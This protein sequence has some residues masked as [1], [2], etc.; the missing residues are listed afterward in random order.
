M[1]KYRRRA[2]R[3]PPSLRPMIESSMQEVVG[4]V[5][6]ITRD[7]LMRMVKDAI[8]EY[9]GLPGSRKARDALER[10]VPE[11]LD[12]MVRD[13]RLMEHCGRLY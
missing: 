11:V 9:A 1:G 12:G 2:A 5:Q 8:G 4:K 13:G 6:G 7:E 3:E 10:A